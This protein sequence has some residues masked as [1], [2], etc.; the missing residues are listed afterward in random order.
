VP[1]VNPPLAAAPNPGP[2]RFKAAIASIATF[3]MGA[4]ILG[5]LAM[6]VFS[7]AHR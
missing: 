5:M 2:L 3:V 1:I 6:R 7:A 4:V